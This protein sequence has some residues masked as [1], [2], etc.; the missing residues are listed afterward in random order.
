VKQKL[1]N[2]LSEAEF[3]RIDK[4][5]F[6]DMQ[7]SSFSEYP[8]SMVIGVDE[9]YDK[10]PDPAATLMVAQ[11]MKKEPETIA[12]VGDTSIDIETARRAGMMAIAVSW[13]F[14]SKEQ[15]L[16]HKPDAC[17]E[18]AQSLLDLLLQR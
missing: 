17:I 6:S 7:R 9:R 14:R 11:A 18:T 3:L 15:L 4:A 16:E 5:E 13:G 12:F 2:E 1:H 10:K 8:F